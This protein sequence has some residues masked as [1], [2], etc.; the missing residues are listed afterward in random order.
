MVQGENPNIESDWPDGSLEFVYD[1][2]MSAT[3]AWLCARWGSG[4]DMTKDMMD[5]MKDAHVRLENM[6]AARRHCADSE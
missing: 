3:A 5:C 1:L 4:A 2:W 6:L